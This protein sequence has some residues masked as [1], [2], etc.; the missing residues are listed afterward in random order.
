MFGIAILHLLVKF[1]HCLVL[2]QIHGKHFLLVI[3]YFIY[4]NTTSPS[5]RTSTANKV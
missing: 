1:A 5:F 4:D 3:F 2:A